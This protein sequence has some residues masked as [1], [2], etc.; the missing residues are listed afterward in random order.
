MTKV[1]VNWKGYQ[2][3]SVMT[4]SEVLNRLACRRQGK[5]SKTET[6]I[7]KVPSSSPRWNIGY[8]DTSV[9]GFLHAHQANAGRSFS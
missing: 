9:Y 2:K 3:E 5:S 8:P 7:K 1:D 6:F 4:Q